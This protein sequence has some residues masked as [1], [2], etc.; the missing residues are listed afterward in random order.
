MPPHGR[1]SSRTR[2][3]RPAE[4]TPRLPFPRSARF[5]YALRPA[6]SHRPLCCPEVLSTTH[7]SNTR[8]SIGPGRINRLPVNGRQRASERTHSADTR[9]AD[10]PSSFLPSDRGSYRMVCVKRVSACAFERREGSISHCL[11]PF[12]SVVR[13]ICHG[14]P[15]IPCGNGCT[16]VLGRS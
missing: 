13:A 12:S 1:A 4:Q 16:T 9:R 11:A 10:S 15:A 2:H 5:A 8:L 7:A 14:R 6:V 3:T